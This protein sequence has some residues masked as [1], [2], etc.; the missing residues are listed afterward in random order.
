MSSSTIMPER[1]SISISELKN[2]NL[3]TW[4]DLYGEYFPVMYR[5]ARKLGINERDI[6]DRIHG[7]FT[8]LWE[9]IETLKIEGSVEGYIMQV[10]R[11]HIIDEYRKSKNRE[12]VV[13]YESPKQS[14]D[15]PR[16]EDVFAER[17]RIQK[18]MEIL[19][20][21]QRQIIGM[22]IISQLPYRKAS[23]KL[24]I[25]IGTVQSRLNLAKRKLRENL[26]SP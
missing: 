16:F 25:P 2:R 7:V 14:V 1:K 15:K 22:V 24:G 6:E 5:Y 3:Q 17:V 18:A 9:R 26:V 13:L 23:E 8:K 11:N 10:L 4:T 19:T 21:P 12:R 20:P